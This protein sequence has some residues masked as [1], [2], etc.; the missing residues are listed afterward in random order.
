MFYNNTAILLWLL[1]LGIPVAVFISMSCMK[2]HFFHRVD[3]TKASI[4][5][6]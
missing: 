1:S 4:S 5:T 2:A 3:Y 6:Y